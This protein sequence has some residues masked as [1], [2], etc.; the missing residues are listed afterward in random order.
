MGASAVCEAQG[1]E[2]FTLSAVLYSFLSL[3]NWIF[4]I[5]FFKKV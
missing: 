4:T 1:R 5:F 3:Y 2:R